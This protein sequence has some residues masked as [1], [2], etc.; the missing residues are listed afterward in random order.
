M[1]TEDFAKI[2]DG[3][4]SSVSDTSAQ[5]VVKDLSSRDPV[6][7][8]S[9]NWLKDTS[10]SAEAKPHQAQDSIGDYKPWTPV[11]SGSATSDSTPASQG[12]S[13]SSKP[14]EKKGES[15]VER[16]KRL[17]ALQRKAGAYIQ[18]Y[19]DAVHH[20]QPGLVSVKLHRHK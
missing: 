18:L 7:R 5:P 13:D 6:S 8:D 11:D 14:E 17:F 20:K 4:D 15:A 12:S 9:Y 3:P 2:F 10:A 1:G 19:K 16:M